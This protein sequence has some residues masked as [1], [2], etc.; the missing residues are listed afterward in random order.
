MNH[1]ILLAVMAVGFLGM[2]MGALEDSANT[3]SQ[4]TSVTCASLRDNGPG[5]NRHIVLTDYAVSASHV[6][7]F[8]AKDKNVVIWAPV[9]PPGEDVESARVMLRFG[10][11]RLADQAK[12]SEASVQELRAL[13]MEEVWARAVDS[14]A[15]K[16]LSELRSQHFAPLMDESFRASWIEAVERECIENSPDLKATTQQGI[17]AIDQP[18]DSMMIALKEAYPWLPPEGVV[19]VDVGSQPLSRVAALLIVT[20]GGLCAALLAVSL[21]FWFRARSRRGDVAA[22]VDGGGPSLDS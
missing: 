22:V 21:A 4:P 5:G 2:G 19:W 11:F 20:I 7:S 17:V 18:D 15:S 8:T 14:A 10:A 3:Q 6:R 16:P 1:F 13:S 9:V 12:L